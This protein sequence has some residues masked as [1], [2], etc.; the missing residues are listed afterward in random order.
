MLNC[1]HTYQLPAALLPVE[2][3]VELCPVPEGEHRL[4]RG[5][6][7]LQHL[8]GEAAGEGRGEHLVRTGER[9]RVVRFVLHCEFEL[10]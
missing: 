4:G 3:P 5:R 7:D 6:E 8:P 9:G 2:H 10:N 1:Q